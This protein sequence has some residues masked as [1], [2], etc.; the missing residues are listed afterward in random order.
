MSKYNVVADYGEYQIVEPID[1]N[2]E[3]AKA[4]DRRNRKKKQEREEIIGAWIGSFFGVLFCI[5]M[6]LYYFCIGY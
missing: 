2:L 1:W 3:K 5:G 4:R 6:L